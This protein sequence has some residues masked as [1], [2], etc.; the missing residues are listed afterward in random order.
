M[1]NSYGGLR[2]EVL[3]R[4][5]AIESRLEAFNMRARDLLHLAVKEQ[6][7]EEDR[8]RHLEE[9]EQ[10][11]EALEDRLRKME[12]DMRSKESPPESWGTERRFSTGMHYPGLG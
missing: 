6:R 9:I 1:A 2:A 12:E 3:R 11:L 10:K 4:I 7:D 8:L 5:E